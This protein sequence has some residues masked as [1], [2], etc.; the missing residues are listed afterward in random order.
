MKFFRWIADELSDGIEKSTVGAVCMFATM[1]CIIYLVIKD[2][3]NEF[4]DDL[5]TMAMIVSATLLGVNSVADI[6][7]RTDN[8]TINKSET[9]TITNSKNESITHKEESTEEIPNKRK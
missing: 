7:K 2:G 6:F 1:G 5:L 3:S 4:V 9:T 8:K